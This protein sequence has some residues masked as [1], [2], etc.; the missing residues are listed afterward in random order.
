MASG[1]LALVTACAEPQP[2]S[3][4][5]SISPSPSEMAVESLPTTTLPAT[6]PVPTPAVNGSADVV[7]A[8]GDIRI[9]YPVPGCPV[10]AWLDD[11]IEDDVNFGI[12]PEYL[13]LDD[14]SRWSTHMAVIRID[15]ATVSDWSFRLTSPL[16]GI[17]GDEERSFIS[18]AD[19]ETPI[20]LAIATNKATFTTRFWD[21][22]STANAPQ[23]IPGTVSVTCR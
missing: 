21:S 2:T 6:P 12:Y 3:V 15:G 5:P 18:D 13:T 20:D 8:V 4:L 23:P 19:P 9:A 22:E 7:I 11:A 14:G 16:S 1:L 10:T 17:I